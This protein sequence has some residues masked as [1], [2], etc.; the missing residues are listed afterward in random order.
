MPEF[1]P[2]QKVRLVSL[3]PF[4]K[5]AAVIP[6]LF[7]ASVLTLGEEGIILDRRPGGYWQVRFSRD[8]Y[9]LEAQYL[10]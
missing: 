2:G 1:S 3:P 5:T 6:V 8:S 9:L 7:P 4:V 10:A